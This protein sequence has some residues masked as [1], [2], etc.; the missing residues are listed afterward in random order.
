MVG[1]RPVPGAAACFSGQGL[2]PALG[3][4]QIIVRGPSRPYGS[5]F[6]QRI[7]RAEKVVHN[8]KEVGP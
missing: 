4:G 1:G 6:R 7:L 5:L 3:C 8:N 2:T